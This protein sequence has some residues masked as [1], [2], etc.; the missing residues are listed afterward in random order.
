MTPEIINQKITD[1]LAAKHLHVKAR[2]Q[3]NF[4]NLLIDILSLAVPIIYLSVR[5]VVKGATLQAA[6]DSV[7]EI[8]A[9]IL[10]AASVL[11]FI[12]QLQD[13][14]QKHS[15]L[16]ADNIA[17]VSLGQTLLADPSNIA[18]QWQYFS[19]LV[20]KSEVE[21]R[22][23]LG[24]P[25]LQ[26]KQFAYREALKEQGGATVVCEICRASPFKFKPG[27]CQICGNTAPR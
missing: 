15:E 8:L 5:Y 2:A 17:I 1:S 22:K 23:L 21:D 6:F 18:S 4:W 12:C 7:G 9:G 26:D 16:M 3:L 13:K 14:I 19:G 24:D 11:K 25:K 27:D 20:Q 10:I